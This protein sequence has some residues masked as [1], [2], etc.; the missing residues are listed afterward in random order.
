MTLAKAVAKSLDESRARFLYNSTTSRRS[1]ILL[2][3]AGQRITIV[4][5]ETGSDNRV[6]CPGR[7]RYTG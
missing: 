2:P 3:A 6:D 4:P 5:I 1:V 7:H